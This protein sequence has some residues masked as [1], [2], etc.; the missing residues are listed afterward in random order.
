MSPAETHAI[1]DEPATPR[2]F[3]SE[4]APRPGSAA[5]A[6]EPAPSTGTIA[7]LN[8]EYPCLSH[9]FIEREIRALRENG[10]DI[11]TFSV[12]PPGK[13]GTL[14]ADHA[15]AARET[16]VILA[17]RAGLV[18]DSLLAFLGAPAS[19]IRALVAGQRFS[20]AGLRARLTHAAYAVEGAWLA[21]RL[22]K[23]GIRHVHCHMANNGAAVALLATR[24]DPGLTYS[25]S[26]HG[27]A[28]FFH[29]DTWTL[30]PKAEGAL[31]V[32]CISNFCRA[33]VMAWTDPSRWTRFH[34]VHCGIDAASFTPVPRTGHGPLRLLTVG[35]LHPIKGYP[36]LLEACRRLGEAG[37]DWTL[38]MVGDGPVA[39]ELKD[40]AARL[41]IAG[42]VTFSGAVGQDEI[43]E[44]YDAAHA[45]VVSSFMEGVPVVLMEGMASGLAVLSTAVGGIP[46]LL[47]PGRAVVVPPGSVEA[48]A[49]G[50][51]S[52]AK[53][54]TRLT[55]IGV[56]G[57]ARVL[58]EFSIE[59]SARGMADLFRHYLHPVPKAR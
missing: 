21:R 36:L 6:T 19:A 45:I 26:I 8:S 13:H 15:R 30:A 18:L 41:G 37:F 43:K 33:Q 14:G 40:L 23:L 34:V 5:G 11:R 57:R 1:A 55:D 44:H 12:R 16:T 22:K 31:F 3:P 2:R 47:E 46:E 39:A 35:R 54:R 24:Y 49:E 9:T 56:A 25:L 53:D 58:S 38:D 17:S 48:L 59:Q 20:P 10:F 42:R 27:S 32:R 28:E 29:V 50:L 7:Y 51:I 52:L 4:P